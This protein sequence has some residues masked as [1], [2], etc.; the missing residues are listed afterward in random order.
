MNGLDHIRAEARA[1]DLLA[2]QEKKQSIFVW[3]F[4][5]FLQTINCFT[6]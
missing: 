1:R 3:L 2:K 5:L 4:A 6:E